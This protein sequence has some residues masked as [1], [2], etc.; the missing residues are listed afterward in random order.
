MR[1]DLGVGVQQKALHAG[2]A[3]PRALWRRVRVA[4]PRAKAPHRLARPLATGN[5]LL[6]RGGQGAGER[7]GG[8]AQGVLS[9]GHRGVRARLQIP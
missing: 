5:A 4:K 2:T 1:R 7:R 9:S 8:V 6:H 3:G